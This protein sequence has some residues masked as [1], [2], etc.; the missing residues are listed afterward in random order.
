MKQIFLQALEGQA[1]RIPAELYEPLALEGERVAN[2]LK[3]SFGGVTRLSGALKFENMI[4]TLAVGRA[5]L[6]VRPKTEPGQDWI[7]SVL[8]LLTEKPT[9]VFDNLPASETR[10]QPTFLEVFARSYSARLSAALA[11]E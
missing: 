10:H 7:L 2:E 9:A 1:V 6:E 8:D 3:L 11:M 4:G 5:V